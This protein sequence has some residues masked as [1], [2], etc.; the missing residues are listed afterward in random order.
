MVIRGIAKD[1]YGLNKNCIATNE[2]MMNW[3]H[4]LLKLLFVKLQTLNI[5]RQ[6][7][8]SYHCSSSPVRYKCSFNYPYF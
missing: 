8:D 7:A 1:M 6:Y 3:F 5:L 2:N 4:S